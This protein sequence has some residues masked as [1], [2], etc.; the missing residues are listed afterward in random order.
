M[1]KIIGLGEVLLRLSPEY[2]KRFV[3]T[4]KM[5]AFYGGAEAN[6]LTACA[7]FGDEAVFLTKLP[8]NDIGQAAVNTL[9]SFGVDTSFI[10]R[11]GERMG[12][13]FCDSGNSV[14]PTKVI[15]DRK[16]SSVSQAL[17]DEYDFETAMEGADWL[18]W[19]GITPALSDSCAEAVRLACECA[20]KHGMK[21]SCDLNY[22]G[23]LWSPEQAQKVM[24][25]LMKYVDVCIA[26]ESDASGCLGIDT[27]NKTTA[28]ILKELKD[29]F[30]FEI[31]AT[32]RIT[33][34]NVSYNLWKGMLYDG[35]LY[36]AKDMTLLPVM[37]RTGAGDALSGGLIHGLLKWEDRQKIIEFA[38][39]AGALKATAAGDLMYFSEEEVLALAE[40]KPAVLR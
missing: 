38:S 8:D 22:R 31:T 10:I 3:N 24:V 13:Y 4:A 29:T 9:R 5:Q 32:A 37:D 20:K 27:A 25:P 7:C 19:S 17:P 40:R 23:K 39:A 26:N 2:G 1:A 33:E 11:G 12:I 36:E 16:G 35:M 28:G 18:H 21:V 6:A 34:M 15:Y 14:R 30:S